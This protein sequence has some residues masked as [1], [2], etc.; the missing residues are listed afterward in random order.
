M[1]P[2]I[3]TRPRC[4]PLADTWPDA[5]LAVRAPAY[6]RGKSGVVFY[7]YLLYATCYIATLSAAH[8]L[9]C[10]GTRP[11][12]EF[13]AVAA[14]NIATITAVGTASIS[15][16]DTELA[17][18]RVHRSLPRRRSLSCYTQVGE[19][20]RLTILDKPPNQCALCECTA[21]GDKCLCYDKR[22]RCSNAREPMPLKSAAGSLLVVFRR[23]DSKC[24]IVSQEPGRDACKQRPC[25][26]ARD[27]EAFYNRQR[28]HSALGYLSPEEYENTTITP[29]K[30]T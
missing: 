29:T 27:I 13:T 21:N 17:L 1:V 14:S 15:A 7:V 16:G 22:S 19:I 6:D 20:P 5:S 18:R 10:P 4:P 9:E 8:A 26:E 24:S 23:I 12:R 11:A 2:V 25:Q 28:R 3:G 30:E